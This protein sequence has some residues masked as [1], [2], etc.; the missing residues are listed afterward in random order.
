MYLHHL[1]L[2]TYV[3]ISRAWVKKKGKDSRTWKL[4]LQNS[5]ENWM[6]LMSKLVSAFLSWKYTPS[7][8]SAASAVPASAWD[9]SIEAA[10]IHTGRSTAQI[11]Q[12]EDVESVAEAIAL[13]GYL[14][15]SPES[16]SFAISFK[17]LELFHCIR[18]RKPLFSIE[19]YAKVFCDL[20]GVCLS[21][22]ITAVS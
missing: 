21:I 13:N 1:N 3:K 10:D 4:R 15:T 5:H 11:Y 14:P 20:H 12:R 16:P 22:H 17:S 8:V 9:F 19:A 7:P 18:I 6:P 2:L